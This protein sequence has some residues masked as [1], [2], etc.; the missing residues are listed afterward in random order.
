MK[1]QFITPVV[2]VFDRNGRP[3]PEQNHR[4]Y[5][6]LVKGGVSGM[7]VLGSTGEFFAMDM[8]TSK[9][10]IDLASGYA[11][12]TFR[13]FAGAS[14]MD[15]EESIALANYALDKGASGVMIISPYYVRLSQESIFDYYATIARNVAGK[16]FLYNFPDRTGYSI[17]PGT[18]L[19][20]ATTFKNI[21][22]LKDTT[23]DMNHTCDV[24]KTVKPEVPGFEIFSGFD[25]NFAH[26]VLSGGNGC[27]GALSNF[28]PDVFASW[29]SAV[30]EQDFNR[31]ARHQRIVDRMMDLYGIGDPFIP[32]VKKALVLRGVIESDAC[33]K[34]LRLADDTQSAKV[35][36]LLDALDL[37]AVPAL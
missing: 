36:A 10:F 28:A 23:L 21:V 5:D 11:S 25:N 27:I 1:S 14:R 35:R 15:P 4:L 33:T 2:S 19:K 6:H 22:G 17:S 12:D 29:M 13:V 24:I 31:I 16:I 8:P 34:P 30:D 9:A 18:V 3:D 26:N 7:A 20:L 37:A 32:I